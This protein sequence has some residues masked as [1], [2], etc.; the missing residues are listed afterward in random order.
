MKQ[1]FKI[2]INGLGFSNDP[3]TFT[4]DEIRDIL[5]DSDKLQNHIIDIQEES[6]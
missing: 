4:A 2:T 6:C 3:L 5:F 1:T